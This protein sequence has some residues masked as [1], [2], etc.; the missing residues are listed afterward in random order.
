M[1]RLATLPALIL[2]AALMGCNA[3]PTSSSRFPLVL[4]GNT[5]VG[6]YFQARGMDLWDTFPISFAAGYGLMLEAR[7]TPYAGVGLGYTKNWRFGLAPQRWG[8]IWWE[9]S[10]G[11][12]IYEYYRYMDYRDEDQRW[13][14]GDPFWWDEDYRYR[15]NS[16][17]IIPGFSQQGEAFFPIIPPYYLKEPW[18]FPNWSLWT[19]FD[20]EA[21]VFVG[22]VGV[23]V[24]VSP[25]QLL[26]FIAGLIT[27]DPAWDDPFE[28][29]MA[30]WPDE[31]IEDYFEGDKAPEEVEDSSGKARLVEED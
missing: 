25:L 1:G 10:R 12:P 22:V 21:S 16:W 6:S 5:S 28:D 9:R 31:G 29:E 18:I 13:E 7:A 14:G 15:A 8:P 4:G 2:V 11:I 24:G 26:D 23:R 3:A 30:T 20:V 19:L 27:W 17:V